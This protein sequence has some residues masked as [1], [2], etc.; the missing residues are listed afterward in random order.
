MGALATLIPAAT[1]PTLRAGNRLPPEDFAEVRREMVLG[2][3][4]WDPQVGDVSTLAPFPLLLARSTWRQLCAWTEELA[5]ELIAAEAELLGRP[6]LHHRLACLG[7]FETCCVGPRKNPRRRR[8]LVAS[9]FIQC[10]R[11][12]GA[13]RR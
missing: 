2:G 4:K 9:I 7:G 1:A 10:A 12:A 8:A 3:F 5:R 13:S 11:A 6:E